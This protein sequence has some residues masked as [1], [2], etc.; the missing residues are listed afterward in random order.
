MSQNEGPTILVTGTT[1]QV[2]FELLNYLQGLGTL[3]AADRRRLDL[4]N[5]DQIRE[6]IRS[7]KPSIVINPAAYTAVDQAESD[8]AL[9]QRINGEAPGIIAEEV[10]RIGGV[11]IHYST[12]YVFD[13]S[14]LDGPYDEDAATNPLNVYGAT[15]LAGER[16][17]AQ[18]GCPYFVFRTSWVYGV[19]GRN[20]LRTMLRLAEERSELRIVADQVGAPTWCGTIAAITAHIAALG[21]L[22]HRG[23]R[24]WWAER[25]GVYHLTTSGVT[26]WAGFAEAIFEMA[27]PERQ[28]SVA[29]IASDEFPVRAKRPKNSRLS[30][31]KLANT[32]GITSPD[33]RSALEMCIA[34]LDVS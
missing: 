8:A 27:L 1:G 11:V 32:F 16:A 30:N 25:S 19:R 24:D 6:V 21:L 3:V 18:V 10:R 23:D 28:I 34:H 13:G 31:A 29:S 9:A 5:F 26:T 12:D 14:K 2:G 22:E 17:L 15:K 4:S 33:W 7:T 20:F